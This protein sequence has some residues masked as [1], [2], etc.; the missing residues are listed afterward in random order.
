LT[1]NLNRIQIGL[2]RSIPDNFFPLTCTLEVVDSTGA[3]DKESFTVPKWF[4]GV[5]AEYCFYSESWF[6][7]GQGLSQY[8]IDPI[9][10]LSKQKSMPK[11][12]PYT[13]PIQKKGTKNISPL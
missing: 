13:G 9:Y 3:T 7:W 4:T 8:C 6:G 1:S 12:E 2:R 5:G 10:S 11:P